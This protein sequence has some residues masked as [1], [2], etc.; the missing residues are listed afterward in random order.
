MANF[1]LSSLMRTRVYVQMKNSLLILAL[2]VPF[3]DCPSQ[4]PTLWSEPQCSS[5]VI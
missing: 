4:W 1:E 3:L 5:S 2:F